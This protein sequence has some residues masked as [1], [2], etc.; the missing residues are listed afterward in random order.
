MR[1]LRILTVGEESGMHTVSEATRSA[2]LHELEAVAQELERDG[3]SDRARRLFVG[4]SVLRAG[5]QPTHANDTS[6]FLTTGEAAEALGIRSVNTIKR[7]VRDGLL[8][9]HQRGGRILVSKRSVAAMRDSPAVVRRQAASRRIDEA[10]A[11]FGDEGGSNES[12]DLTMA[13][14]GRKPWDAPRE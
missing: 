3:Q 10:F 1:G 7:W 6:P 4:L 2:A 11:P 8:E 13:W 12:D 14:S 9:G 5:V